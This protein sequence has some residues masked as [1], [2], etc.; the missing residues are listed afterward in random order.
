MKIC[1][2][3]AGAIGG[4]V[5][6]CLARLDE[7]VSLVARGEHLAAMRRDGLRVREFEDG[8]EFTV[9]PRCVGSAAELGLQDLVIVTLKAHQLPGAAEDI[10]ALLGPE[11][12]VVPAMNGI[13]WWYFHG[14][15]GTWGERRVAAVDPGGRV[16]ARVGPERV[17][18]ATV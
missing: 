8:E 2:Y 9:H 11:T 1:V 4:Y 16:W 18:G 10:A 14:L 13:P 17:V 6:A 5:G 12:V 3:G 7:D 15:S